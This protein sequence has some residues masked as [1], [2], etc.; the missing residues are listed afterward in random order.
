MLHVIAI[1]VFT[2]CYLLLYLY[3]M[4]PHSLHIY[5][6][7]QIWNPQCLV[8]TMHHYAISESVPIHPNRSTSNV[9]SIIS[10]KSY[11]YPSSYQQRSILPKTLQHSGTFCLRRLGPRSRLSP[12]FEFGDQ[13]AQTPCGTPGDKTYKNIIPPR[14]PKQRGGPQ[15]MEHSIVDDTVSVC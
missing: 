1:S 11:P 2:I 5:H 4:F 13:S 6:R 12:R 8:Q 9:I 15:R 3:D 14:D 7:C 10:I